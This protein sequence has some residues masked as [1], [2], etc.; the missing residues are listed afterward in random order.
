MGGTI[1]GGIIKHVLGQIIGLP[2]YI[3]VMVVQTFGLPIGNPE[4]NWLWNSHCPQFSL[5]SG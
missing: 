2:S 5:S 4:C 1:L 3:I